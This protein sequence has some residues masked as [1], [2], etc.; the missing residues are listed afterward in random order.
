MKQ[1]SASRNPPNDTVQAVAYPHFSPTQVDHSKVVT[2]NVFL[3]N[4]A[5]ESSDVAIKSVVRKKEKSK[6]KVTYC[7]GT[8]GHELESRKRTQY[9][10]STD[11]LPRSLIAKCAV[12]AHL[13]CDQ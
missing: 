7:P 3:L 5:N 11:K 9:K 2:E 4:D 8:I 1:E 10:M 13:K 6:G 12:Y